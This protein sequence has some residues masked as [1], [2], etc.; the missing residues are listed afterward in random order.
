MVDA[1]RE[2]AHSTCISVRPSR[3]VPDGRRASVDPEVCADHVR[4]RFGYGF[5]ISTMRGV[6]PRRISESRVVEV[7]RIRARGPSLASRATEHSR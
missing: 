6:V 1:F 5:A 4:D 3:D 2:V 7:A